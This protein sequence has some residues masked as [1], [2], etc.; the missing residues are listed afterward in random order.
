[1]K[2]FIRFIPIFLSFS[3]LFATWFNDVPRT[4]TQPNG[5]VIN[6][7]ITGDQ[8]GRRLHDAD[9]FT[10]ILNEVD[11]FYHYADLDLN[12][13]LTLSDLVV[14][15]G[16]PAAFGL[17]PGLAISVED[18][19]RNKN[20]YHN[21]ASTRETRDAPTSGTISQLNVFIRFADDPEFIFPRSHYDVVFQTDED[22]SSMRHYFYEVSYNTLTVNTYHFPETVGDFNASY[23]DPQ[24][25]SYYEPYSGSNP[26]GYQNS[27]ERTER[28]HT[29]LANA[30][31][32]IADQVSPIYDIDANDDGYVDA[33]SFVI[34]GGPG[35]WAD[36]L[37]PHRWSLYTQNVTINGAQVWDY[38]FMLSESWYFNVGV[39]CH[40][41]FHVLGAP[42]LYHYDGGGAPQ[43]VG[44]W[45]LMESN[46]NPPQY[47]CAFMKWK[48]GDWLPD[49][50]EIT[51]SGTYTLNPLQQQENAIY[52]IPSP[53]SETEYFVVEYRKKEGLYDVNT[54]GNRDG[55]VVYR[56]NTLAG[57]GN[58]S[59][60]P[61][62]VYCYRPG[63]TLTNNGSFDLAPYSSDYNHTELNDGTDP[64]CYL[65]NYG[66]GADGGLNM[67]NVTSAGETISFTVSFGVPT[68]EL[69]T[70]ELNFNLSVGDFENQ[71][72]T[73]SNGGEVES[74]LN[75]TVNESGSL[76]FLNPQGGPDGGNY[77]WTSSTAE[78]GMEYEWID[79]ENNS[80]QLNFSHNDLF[81][82]TPIDLPFDFDFFGE[83]YNF[84]E[85][86][87]NGWVGWNS[88]NEN[89]WLNSDI[90]SPSAP[91]P[92]IFGFWDDFN[93]NNDDGNANSDG[94]IF[95]HVNQERVVIWFD[96]VVRWNT[97]DWGQ[98][99]FQIVLFADGSFATNY[100]DMEGVI[101][102]GTVGFQN[103]DGS[104]GTQIAANE[105]FV[106]DESSWQAATAEQDVSWMILSSSTGDLSGMLYGGE[107]TEIYVQV[108]TSDLEEGLYTANINV[109]AS[110]VDPAT[111]DV[112]LYVSGD[113][114]TPTLPNIDIS[115]SENGI[116]DLPENVD[117]LFSNVASRYTHIVAPNGDLIQ[118]L[119]QNNFSDAQVLHARRALESYL[120]DIIGSDWGSD[121][122]NIANAIAASNAIMF[123]L[124]DEDEYENP[125]LWALMDAGVNGQDLLATEVFPEGAP[126]YMN[127]SERD[128]TYEEVLHFVHGF[129][130]QLALPALQIALESAMEN[131]I[132]NDLYN[133]LNDL[134][135]EDFDEEYLAMGL[136]CY[137]GI[138]AHD[139]N[140]DGYCGDHEYA[141]ITREAMEAGDPA[142]FNIIYGFLGET[143]EYTAVLPDGFSSDFY[144]NLQDGLEYTNRS[145]YVKNF[146]TSGD[147]SINFY[148]NDFPNEIVGNDGDNHF[149]GFGGDDILRGGAGYDR[150][151]FQGDFVYY[152]ILPPLVTGDSS[153]QIIDL[154]P[155]RDGTDHLY[156][157]EEITFNGVVYSLSDF[158]DMNSIEQLPTEFALHSPFPNPFNPITSIS[159]DVAE[160]GEVNLAVHDL[161]GRLIRTLHQGESNRG[162]Y[163]VVWDAKDEKGTPVS[164]GIYFIKLTTS[165]L[166][167]TQKVLFLK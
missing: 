115:S 26:N 49:L 161:N 14:G 42:D 35:D 130:I 36:L 48:Y 72:V 143:W 21:A 111:I 166:I 67:L 138:W 133:P 82:D 97:D 154:I 167:K 30:L 148:G 76:P 17:E 100:R 11:G 165:S 37:W 47:P 19:E 54:P 83:T 129:G 51:E 156:D 105:A 46:T 108:V 88:A 1:M 118:F 84:V 27:T 10:I 86:N 38:L 149:T 140:G 59:G 155:N 102:S 61:D 87:A 136:E 132:E 74:Q 117:P 81:A 131:A 16:D 101:N 23:Q 162:K 41:F 63:G 159:Y 44:G 158:L 145:Q 107:S 2:L 120:T 96:D 32:S 28:E 22:E 40:E 125:D 126:Q 58:A 34:Y 6:C 71:T 24:P 62:E 56:I 122:A 144:L 52:K 5:E 164:T 124:N 160:S 91:R 18:Y 60:P 114:T 113:N 142:L 116:V 80:T 137:F 157:F 73:L 128:A 151:I 85:V 121:K 153:F 9:D 147:L 141:F 139:P 119:I 75:Y 69:N 45:D 134:P 106:S 70:E 94:D 64:A 25:R 12:G 163:S 65:Y 57:N 93:P 127:S 92:A 77:Y 3:A 13:D 50:P 29:L 20:F 150:V 66:N 123:L 31:N 112:N 146:I 109:T 104:M 98:F 95:Y 99:D 103:Q 78:P 4:I 89:A 7:F 79:I 110:N 90:P 43:A 53:N 8:Y 55:I 152:A 33:V 68:I 135:E 15:H 39:L